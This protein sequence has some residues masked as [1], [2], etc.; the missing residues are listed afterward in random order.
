MINLQKICA[1]I[2]LFPRSVCEVG[3]N[4]PDKCSLAW[5]TE[6][7]ETNVILVEPLPWCAEHLREKFPNATVI[8]AAC[9][10]HNGRTRLFDRG[11]GS[12]IEQVPVGS[13]PDEHK[14]HSGIKR[15]DFEE[16]FVRDTLVVRF[17][18]IDPKNLDIL[19]VDIEGAE[20]FV[21][22]Q[23]ISRPKLVRVETHFSH[24]GYQ[25]PHLKEI[26]Q[27]M[28]ILGYHE[29][30]HDVSDTLWIR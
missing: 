8:E 13:A 23:M 6:M 19:C 10:P 21:I 5:C 25:N 15:Q 30:L 28:A 9:G 2:G 1:A 18:D 7:P 20:W 12:W 24:S 4:E 27:R 29:L 16:R 17:E 14:S 22:E 11:E 26:K 3:V